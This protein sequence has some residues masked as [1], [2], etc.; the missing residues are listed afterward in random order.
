MVGVICEGAG[1]RRSQY[2]APVPDGL[3][4]SITQGKGSGGGLPLSKHPKFRDGMN[5]Q[6]IED[7]F[8]FLGT[9]RWWRELL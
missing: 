9:E 1:W 4:I 6:K 7:F 5:P 2:D 8:A 3:K